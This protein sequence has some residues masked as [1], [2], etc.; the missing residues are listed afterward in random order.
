MQGQ[1]QTLR[2]ERITLGK[3]ANMLCPVAAQACRQELFSLPLRQ[4]S[5]LVSPLRHGRWA[6]T[7]LQGTTWPC[8]G[9]DR[10]TLHPRALS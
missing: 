1:C 4:P 8:S 5:S 10:D 3:D 7:N 2:V 9:P 6:E